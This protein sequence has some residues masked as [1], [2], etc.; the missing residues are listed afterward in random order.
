M[1]KRV[2]SQVRAMCVESDQLLGENRVQRNAQGGLDVSL[3]DRYGC[4]ATLCNV[5]QCVAVCCRRCSAG[6]CLGI[7]GSKM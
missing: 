7:V 6:M 5:L 2:M 3:L 4:L 1:C